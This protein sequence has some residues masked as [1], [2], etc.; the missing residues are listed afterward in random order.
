LTSRPTSS[1]SCLL[2]SNANS[3]PHLFS[4]DHL[5]LNGTSGIQIIATKPDKLILC[6]LANVSLY[7]KLL[8][9]ITIQTVNPAEV[10][11]SGSQIRLHVYISDMNGISSA[12]KTLTLQVQPTQSRKRRSPENFATKESTESQKQTKDISTGVNPAEGRYPWKQSSVHH[13]SYNNVLLITV[14]A[15]LVAMVIIIKT[16]TN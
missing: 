11:A 12:S 7:Q 14:V 1:S 5:L 6:G 8:H 2:S 15:L 10:I 9:E 16:L 13:R 4:I 3:C